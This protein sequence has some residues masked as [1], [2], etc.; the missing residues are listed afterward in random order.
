MR[1]T[2]LVTALIL[3]AAHPA[4]A[5]R[6][7]PSSNPNTG[8]TNPG[9]SPGNNPS[10]TN[11]FPGNTN[12]NTIPQNPSNFPQQ[13]PTIFLSGTVLMDDGSK[14]NSDI[15]IERVCNGNPRPE[16]HTDSKGHFSF[17]LG[18]NSMAFADAS[19]SSANDGF[20]PMGQPGAG[21]PSAS[22]RL[23]DTRGVNG[24]GSLLMNCELRASYPGYRSDSISLAQRRPM[25]NP[26]VGTIVLHRLSNVQGTTISA[27]TAMAPKKAQKDYD[28]GLQLAQK[29]QLEQAEKHL[30]QAVDLYPKYAVAWFHLGGVQQVQGNI[31]SAK[32]SYQASIEADSR[33]VSPYD[34][35]ALIAA[36]EGKWEDAEAFSK[37]V[38]RLNPVE[39]PSSFLY[40][41]LASYNLKK[42]DE[43]E[44]SVKE[45]LKLDTAHHY[46][47]AENLLA[48]LLLEKGNYS[49][50]ATHLRAYLALVPN[51]Q[52]A[53]VLKQ[54]LLKIEQATATAPK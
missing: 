50:A 37:Q 31:A 28:K 16:A 5:Q 43:A 29:G 44:K 54:Q 33:Y 18:Q 19:V 6:N 35:L 25:D 30:Q 15:T 3:A 47:Q 52:N 26:N 48:Q 24:Y 20:G 53:D 41:A 38:I 42:T 1:I 22:S 46:P 13:P 49:D 39:F 36:Q 11:N 14:P 23:G 27:T 9:A 4:I 34:R 21:F 40:N 17:Q 7:G 32:K 51:A 45:V 8:N 12:R 10:N 2:W